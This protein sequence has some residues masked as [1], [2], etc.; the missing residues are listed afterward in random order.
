[1]VN[2][3]LIVAVTLIIGIA[4]PLIIFAIIRPRINLN[5]ALSAAAPE[6]E[7]TINKEDEPQASISEEKATAGQ[8]QASNPV[9]E[10]NQ[11]PT[12]ES[13]VSIEK[14]PV[15][16]ATP[17]PDPESVPAAIESTDGFAGTEWRSLDVTGGGGT[18]GI[19]A[20]PTNPDV[21]YMASDNSGLYKTENGGDSWFSVTSNMGA[22]RLGFVTLDP[23]NPEVIYVTAS[24]DF[25]GDEEGGA[26]GEMYRSQNDGR[27]WEFVTD[28]MGFQSSFPSQTALAMLYDPDNPA[29]FDQDGD[30]LTDMIIVAAWTG[31]ADPPVGGIWRSEDEGETFTHLALQDKNM[32]GVWAFPGDADLLFATTN[33]GQVYRSPDLGD[34]WEAITADLPLT[35]VADLALHPADANILY[36]TCRTCLDGQTPVWK[37]VDG[38]Q[39]WQPAGGGLDIENTRGFPRILMDRNDPETLYL[40]TLQAVGRE[41]SVNKTS[42]GGDSWETMPARLVLPDGRPFHTFEFERQL[43]I[44]QSVDGTLY[45]GGSAAWRFPDGDQNDGVEVW[46]PATIGLGNVHVNVIEVDPQN[47]AILYQGISDFGTYKSINQGETFHRNLGTGWPVTVENF[48]WNGPYYSNYD[49]CSLSCSDIC[50]ATGRIASGGTY[51]YAISRQDSNIVY[52]AFGSGSGGTEHG[53]IN[54]SLDGGATWFPVGFQLEA[55]F[56]LDPDTCVPYGFREVAIDLSNNQ[57]VFALQEI[58]DTGESIIY[59]SMDGG[60]SWQKVF[61]SDR[62]ISKLAVSPVDSNLMVFVLPNAVYKSE[63]GGTP[64][65]WQEITP[66]EARQILEV[67]LSPH[68]RDVFVIGTHAQGIYYTEDG[69]QTWQHNALKPFF[70]QQVAQDNSETLSPDEITAYK[71]DRQM[72]RNITTVVFDPLEPDAFFVAGRQPGRASIGVAKITNGSQNWERLPL[73]GLSQRS[74]FDLAIDP[75]GEYLYAGTFNGTYQF[76]LR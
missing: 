68:N 64:E 50:N 69:G 38:G 44:G 17:T 29:R 53:G 63:Q 47:P 59:K 4:I 58:P 48:V 13:L 51:A 72:L 19:A 39:S 70:D 74:I 36:V 18:T 54:K 2:K 3:K 14:E 7:Q 76:R 6:Q 30:G 20:H 56:E 46:E 65:S 66:G 61:T 37:T 25:G 11:T 15:V 75:A 42:N 60:E 40:T 22:Y 35:Q 67:S 45:S 49:H 43:T 12:P 24:T 9:V 21:V 10:E 57:I 73:A 62:A 1:M 41:G 28:L 23:L 8:A 32:T 52:S 34:S 33:D 55:G 31:P 16:E 71:S 27:S 5:N 26:T